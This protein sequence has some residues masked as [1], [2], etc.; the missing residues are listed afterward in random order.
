MALEAAAQ[1]RTA[2]SAWLGAIREA[3]LR[4]FASGAGPLPPLPPAPP[5]ALRSLL[6]PLDPRGQL[7]VESVVF[8]LQSGS[9]M[10]NLAVAA[11]DEDYL[12]VYALPPASRTNTSALCAALLRCLRKL[13]RTGGAAL[14][15]AAG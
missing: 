6:S 14:V 8:A 9:A 12:L 11:S 4:A 2:V 3:D 5:A 15:R 13:V 10:Y 1:L 7:A